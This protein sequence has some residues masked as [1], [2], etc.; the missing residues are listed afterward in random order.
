ML[1]H[2]SFRYYIDYYHVS[3][4]SEMQ[5]YKAGLTS[6]C[7]SPAYSDTY[8]WFVSMSFLT[9][10]KWI[11]YRPNITMPESEQSLW[12]FLAACVCRWCATG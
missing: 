12:W 9:L 8:I 11:L 4:L 3:Q 10:S 1:I 6:K 2:A 7:S 5:D